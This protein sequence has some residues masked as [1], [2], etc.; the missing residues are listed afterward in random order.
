MPNGG[1]DVILS[2]AGVDHA[3]QVVHVGGHARSA[4]LCHGEPLAIKQGVGALSR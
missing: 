3:G 2:E 4:R 1:L